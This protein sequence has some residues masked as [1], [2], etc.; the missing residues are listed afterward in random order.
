MSVELLYTSAPRGLR[1]GSRGFCTVLSTAGMPLNLANRLESLSGYRQLFPPQHPQASE[2]PVAYSH[3]RISLS[4]QSLSVLSRVGDYGTDYSGRTNKIAHHVVVDAAEAPAAGPAWLLRHSGVMRSNWDGNCETPATGPA[5]PQGDQQP[6]ICH[7]WQSITGDAGWGGVVA[8][9]LT[10]RSSKPTWIVYSLAQQ[11]KLLELIDESIALLPASERWQATFSTYAANLSP[12]IDCRVRCVVEGSEEARLAAA[13]GQ[14]IDLTVDLQPAPS[15]AFTERAQ[16]GAPA[17]HEFRASTAPEPDA[18]ALA[19]ADT[20]LP[21]PP[22]GKDTLSPPPSP[23][24][25]SRRLPPGP[26]LEKAPTASRNLKAAYILGAL[27]AVLAGS[28]AVFGVPQ[29]YHRVSASVASNKDTAGSAAEAEKAA[30]EKAAAEKAAAEKAAA[31]KAAA[32]K[33]A[34]EKAAAEKA[35]AEKAA[36]E[37]AAAEKAAAEKAA[38][39]KAAAEKAAAEKAAAEKA[40]AEK[41]AAEKAAAEKAAAEKAAAE[42]AAAEKAAAEKAAA[43]RMALF[44][45]FRVSLDIESLAVGTID[46]VARIPFDKIEGAQGSTW[47]YPDKNALEIERVAPVRLTTRKL[48]QEA[49]N[50]KLIAMDKPFAISQ[51]S[52]I[53]EFK[54]YSRVSTPFSKNPLVSAFSSA[55]N[56]EVIVRIVFDSSR[57]SIDGLEE[58]ERIATNVRRDY[59]RTCK[60]SEVLRALHQSTSLTPIDDG[61]EKTIPLEG[62]T[63]KEKAITGIANLIER[64]DSLSKEASRLK[65]EYEDRTAA[66]KAEMAGVVTDDAKTALRKKA[67][68][69]SDLAEKAAELVDQF[70]N[71]KNSL[72]EF[73]SGVEVD[74]GTLSFETLPEG[75]LL[76][77]P[78]ILQE[79]NITILIKF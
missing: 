52:Q 8:E 55:A 74:L 71:L 63:L 25:R 3:F 18:R 38:A 36:A 39:E 2:N 41:A 7:A 58:L 40:A 62:V 24:L 10:V 19:Y 44:G 45:P 26:P 33:A 54:N 21:A 32:E 30:A 77:R 56:N 59:E 23:A 16:T 57:P 37:K 13:R 66:I 78:A 6:A 29:I 31:E 47:Y 51:I 15:S 17:A 42:K 35:A 64:H 79:K 48:N 53:Q 9:A 67:R 28:A 75:G 12:D 76:A 68:E 4:G 14:V 49:R 60:T 34:A 65:S 50:R 22:P 69:F 43:E 1:Q 70:A 73:A 72:A 11:S 61:P 46:G 20:P 27:L 5:I